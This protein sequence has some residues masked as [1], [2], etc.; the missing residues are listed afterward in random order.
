ML[1]IVGARKWWCGGCFDYDY[2]GGGG[3][4]GDDA[5]IHYS[6]LLAYYVFLS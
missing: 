5:C 3:G 4:G 6:L 2:D 1:C